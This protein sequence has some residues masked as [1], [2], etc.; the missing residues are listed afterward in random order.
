MSLFLRLVVIVWCALCVSAAQAEDIAFGTIKGIKV[1]DFPDSKVT[2]IYFNS[3]AI[4]QSEP[5]Q[6]IGN[7][8]HSLHEDKTIKQMLSVAL[9]A[10]MSG[11]KIRAYAKMDGSCEIDLIGVQDTY[12]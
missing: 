1:Y 12:F 7:I 5:C 6:G 2:K 8:T 11:K 3:D 9:S 4:H 10:Y